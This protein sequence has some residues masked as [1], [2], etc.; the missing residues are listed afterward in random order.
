MP[1]NL[2][3][4]GE[5]PRRW[6]GRWR[7]RLTLGFDASGKQVRKA[8]YGKT[9]AECQAKL[10]EL[11]RQRAE[12]ADLLGD[13]PT[14]SGY[15]SEWLRVKAREVSSRSV[16]IYRKEIRHVEKHLGRVHL[17]KLTPLQVQRMQLAIAD[18]VSARQAKQSRGVLHNALQ[19]AVRLGMLPRNPVSAVKPMRYDA[20]E[21]EIWTAAEI[22]RFLETAKHSRYHNL[23]YTAL[24]TG[25][26]PGELFALH[27][28]DFTGEKLHVHRTLTT[29]NGRVVIG[30]AKTTYSHRI[31]PVPS[32][33]AE[34]LE[35]Q[36]RE[37][38]LVF[39]SRTGRLLEHGNVLRSIRD[40]AEKA[41]S[42][43]E[44]VK[45]I[46][47][48]DL[49]HTFAS[50]AIAAGWDVVTLSRHLGHADVSFTLRTYAHIFERHKAR[51]VST[52][53]ELLGR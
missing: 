49:R 30:E 36:P 9:A 20:P 15:L 51:E 5:T 19:D 4:Q 42:E 23:Y 33:T 25:L 43:T 31:I 2:S 1:K 48:H 6:K 22:Q 16:D 10:D 40:L 8:V 35:A 39:C 52:L 38:E 29:E 3:G 12:G 37:A 17:S 47:T 45:P 44:K 53:D 13:D 21:F 7:A 28:E 27:W 41:S 26:R 32:D 50:M 14:I 11:K 18:E 24:T 46:R 34:L